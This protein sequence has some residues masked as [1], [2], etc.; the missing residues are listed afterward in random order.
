MRSSGSAFFIDRLVCC[1]LFR[2]DVEQ[3][4]TIRPDRTDTVVVHPDRGRQVGVLTEELAAVEPVQQVVGQLQQ[5]ARQAVLEVQNVEPRDA[6]DAAAVLFVII[7]HFF[8]SEHS[9]GLDRGKT[10]GEE[11]PEFFGRVFAH[12]PRIA[13]QRHRRVGGRHDETSAR[14]Q[15]PGDL[16]H[17]IA[18]APDMFDH[19]ERNHA[20]ETSVGKI[21][22]RHFGLP[23]FDIGQLQQFRR[24]DV[25]VHGDEP[26]GTRRHDF[27]AVAASRA[28]FEHVA[29]DAF[30][31]GVV[32][33]QRALEYEIVGSLRR[34]ALCG[35]NLRHGSCSLFP[36]HRPRLRRVSGAFPANA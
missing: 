33:Q 6:A 16:A 14:A 35:V 25:L 31:C 34:H 9:E 15:H 36:F 5:A 21:Q 18:V 4:E 10:P 7:H 27:D 11:P 19:L 20:V 28:D 17:E 32:G 23:E 8:I 2:G 26:P 29:R 1:P 24:R 13:C 12:V 22:R 3:V 30:R